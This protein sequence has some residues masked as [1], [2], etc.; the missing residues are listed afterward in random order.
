VGLRR[1]PACV[2]L[3]R[4]L[5]DPTRLLGRP[6]GCVRR[7]RGRGRV[8]RGLR[9]GVRGFPGMGGGMIGGPCGGLG[10]GG[11]VV[12]RV[13]RLAGGLRGLPPGA[14]G[15]RARRLGVTAGLRGGRSRS[16]GI[17]SGAGGRTRR[18]TRC[19]CRIACGPSR[20]SSQSSARGDRLEQK[21]RTV[22]FPGP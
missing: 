4:G 20:L 13:V 16:I 2:G 7:R 17:C 22:V 14:L 19:H 8:L 1:Q 10:V 6:R 15:L 11:S 12:G 18:V 5:L 9:G 3:A 21:Q